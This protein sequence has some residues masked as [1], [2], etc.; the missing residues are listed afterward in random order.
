MDWALALSEVVEWTEEEQIVVGDPNLKSHQQGTNV[1][2]S[3]EEPLLGCDECVSSV[4]SSNQNDLPGNSIDRDVPHKCARRQETRKYLKKSCYHRI[5]CTAVTF[6]SA[7]MWR[8]PLNSTTSA[9]I[10]HKK[11][12]KVS[13]GTGTQVRAQMINKCTM[14]MIQMELYNMRDPP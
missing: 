7:F 14:K 9:I 2:W 13:D 3:E 5:K 10:T 4:Y 1:W 6:L 8:R 12:K 11:P